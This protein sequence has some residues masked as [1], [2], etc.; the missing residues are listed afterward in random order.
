MRHIVT[1]I[2]CLLCA[3]T[4]QLRG[5]DTP[6]PKQPNILFIFSDDHSCQSI[7][8]YNKW[9]SAFVREQKITPNIDRLAEQGAIFDRSFCGNSICSP[10]RATVLSGVHTHISG[11]TH[12]GGS[13]RDGVWTFPPALQ[14]A[15]YQTGLIGK[16]HLGNTPAGFDYYRVLPGQGTY[17]NPTFNGP[18]TV[19]ENDEGYT[20]DVIT[21]KSLAWLKARD[22]SKPFI[23]LTHHKAPHRPWEPPERYFKL[24]ADVK[25]PEP[26]TLFDDYSNRTS[27][28][29]EQK[30][31]IGRDMTMA[32]DLK[33]LPPGKTAARLTTEG[34]AAWQANFG[35]RNAAFQQAKLEGNDLTRWKY[36]E[37]MK[38]YLRCVKAVDDSVGQL[39][40]YLKQ[41]GLDSNTVVIY[42]AD[43]SFFNGEHGWFD[44][45]WIYE[46][47]ITMPLIV[48]WP[49]VVKPGTRIQQLVQNIDYAPTFMELAG[50]RAPDSVQGRSMVPLLRGETPTDWRHS[51]YYHYYDP[52]H[53]VQKHYG[54]R[55]ERYTLAHFYPVNEWELFDLEKDPL[56][57]KSVF[58]DPAYAQTVSELKTELNR[59]RTFYK[60]SEE[61]EPKKEKKTATKEPTRKKAKGAR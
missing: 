14:A 7:G 54:I 34:E 41:E 29:R 10:S 51:V 52:G 30:M 43:Q 25:V 45:R 9:L 61:T 13:I 50:Q 57:L 33:V 26:P 56:Q 31:E 21:D 20:T 1:V 27:S 23:L 44:K 47:S 24:L 32:S 46:E 22:K 8:A 37:Y 60:D 36:Q 15:G 19:K 11:V 16:W 59:L 39:L 12:L 53:S 42:S 48:R 35:V 58:S 2:F 55:T 40:E 17:R 49:G 38:D 18:G 4:L 28:A 3:A 6:S 5:A